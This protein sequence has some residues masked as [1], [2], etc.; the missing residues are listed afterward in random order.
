MS[1]NTGSVWDREAGR[2]LIGYEPQD[3]WTRI[4]RG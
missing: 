1:A 3:D 4:I 2:R